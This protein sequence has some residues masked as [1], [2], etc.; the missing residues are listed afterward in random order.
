MFIASS[1]SGDISGRPSHVKANHLHLTVVLAVP[2]GRQRIPN[3][4]AYAE[5]V[6]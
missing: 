1:I 5:I 6:S 4:P 3:I 2:L